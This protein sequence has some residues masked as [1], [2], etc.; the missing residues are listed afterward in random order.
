MIGVALPV[1]RRKEVFEAIKFQDNLYGT[2]ESSYFDEQLR[3]CETLNVGCIA[4]QTQWQIEG[5][6]EAL[7]LYR[8]NSAGLSANMLKQLESIEK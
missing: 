6:P 1:I 3:H 7:T 5:L 2:N 8:V 4:I